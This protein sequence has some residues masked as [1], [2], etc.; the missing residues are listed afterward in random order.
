M[1]PE[2]TLDVF[3]EATRGDKAP[4]AN[5]GRGGNSEYFYRPEDRPGHKLMFNVRSVFTVL[6]YMVM[7]SPYALRDER[8]RVLAFIAENA[9]RYREGV[10]DK[11]YGV[12]IYLSGHD[13][14][15]RYDALDVVQLIG[16][17]TDVPVV[18]KLIADGLQFDL[19]KIQYRFAGFGR[20]LR[21]YEQ[22]QDKGRRII[23]ELR[24][25]SPS[26]R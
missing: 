11:F 16:T 17:V 14:F 3:L 24:R 2:R 9:L 1:N 20:R 13:Y 5:E 22:I 25:R 10:M 19:E 21:K 23:E 15:T 4:W 12:P 7:E 26:Q 8:K 6:A 18:E